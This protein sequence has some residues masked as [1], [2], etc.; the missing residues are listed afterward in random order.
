M[1]A[2]RPTLRALLWCS[3]TALQLLARTKAIACKLRLVAKH[4]SNAEPVG[5][6]PMVISTRSCLRHNRLLNEVSSVGGQD[7]RSHCAFDGHYAMYCNM[8]KTHVQFHYLPRRIDSCR[9]VLRRSLIF[10][11]VVHFLKTYRITGPS[12]QHGKDSLS[13]DD[14]AH[15][16]H[17]SGVALTTAL[18]VSPMTACLVVFSQG[19]SYPYYC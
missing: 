11:S 19:D 14:L 7:Q 3:A 6:A 16:V 10:R 2:D 8:L 9:S 12:K 1:G 15:Q 17:A 18:D 13:T 4:H 5:T